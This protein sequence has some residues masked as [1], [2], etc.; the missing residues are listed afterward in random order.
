MH[1]KWSL[2]LLIYYI[3]WSLY[4]SQAVPGMIYCDPS[5][6]NPLF[7]SIWTMHMLAEVITKWECPLEWHGETPVCHWACESYLVWWHERRSI[8]PTDTCLEVKG[9]PV[10]GNPHSNLT[11]P[12]DSGNQTCSGGPSC[13]PNTSTNQILIEFQRTCK[14]WFSFVIPFS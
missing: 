9:H 5:I 6:G 2:Y 14:T 12:R 1:N 13:P 7:L 10:R 11:R 3:C 8:L 4:I